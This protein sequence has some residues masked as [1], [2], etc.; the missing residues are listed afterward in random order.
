ME[1]KPKPWQTL[2]AFAVIYFVWG[3]TFLAIRVGVQQVPPLLF[4][5]MRFFTAGAILFGYAVARREPLPARREWGSIFLLAFLIFVLNYGLLFTAEQRI[6]SGVASVMMATIPAFTALSE[7]LILRTQRL[8][9]RLA[10]ALLVGIAGVAVLT[11]PTLHL[12][13]VPIDRSAAIILLLAAIAWSVS[14][15]LTRKLPLPSSKVLSSATQMLAGGLMLTLASASFGEFP[16]FHPGA[17][18]ISA[19]LA[20]AYLIVFGSILGFTCYL[21]LIH[22]QS[23][24]RVGTYAYVNPAVAVVLGYFVAHEPIGLRT[25]LGALCILVSVI[26]IATMK[27]PMARS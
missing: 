9:L 15:A 20:L 3:S 11:L 5:A 7:I 26:L 24:T 21:W 13:G 27:K 10:I 19:W 14:S 6:P 22:N 4:A 17:I 1:A 12:A 18:S 23:P 8:T 2:L 16:K 25:L